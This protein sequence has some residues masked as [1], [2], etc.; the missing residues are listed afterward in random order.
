VLV[1][2]IGEPADTPQTVELQIQMRDDAALDSIRESATAIARD[3]LR[4]L[5]ALSQLLI[6]RASIESPAAWPGVDLF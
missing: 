2:R 4:R 3:G 1:S 6:E 5:H